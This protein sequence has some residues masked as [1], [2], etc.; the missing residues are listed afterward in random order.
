MSKLFNH[1]ATV[2]RVA[3]DAP[4]SRKDYFVAAIEDIHPSPEQPRCSRSAPSDS[5]HADA[6][7]RAETDRVAAFS[8][9]RSVSDQQS[10]IQN[11]KSKIDQLPGE[12]SNLHIRLQ[13]PLSCH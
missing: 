9:S 10:K 3:A 2:E 4:A 11:R 12:D 7:A 1:V 8:D 5:R 6:V 13:R